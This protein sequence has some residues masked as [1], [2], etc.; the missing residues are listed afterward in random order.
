MSS[1]SSLCT[2]H[3]ALPGAAGW[4]PLAEAARRAARNVGHLRRL[5]VEK[6][7]GEGKAREVSGGGKRKRYEVREDADPAFARVKFPEQMGTDLRHVTESK[8]KEAID[9][10][11]ILDKWERA[12]AG[13]FEL[14]LSEQQITAQ[15]LV[16]LQA[17]GIEVSRATLYNWYKAWRRGGLAGLVDGRGGAVE[18]KTGEVFAKDDQ[19]FREVQ[20][21]Y[22]LPRRLKLSTCCEVARL[23]AEQSGWKTISDERCRQLLKVMPL[24]VVL[25][26]RMG[27]DKDVAY[28]NECEPYIERTYRTMASNEL[29]CGDHHQFDVICNHEGTLLRPW[30]TAWQ[31]MRSRKIVGWKI[32]AHDPNSD[33]ILWTFRRACLDFG[34]CEGVYIDNGKDYDCYSLNGR[35]KADRWRKRVIQVPLNPDRA[36]VFPSLSVEVTHC[37]KYHGQ[38]KPIERF[39]GTVEGDTPVWDTYC[40]RSTSHK[41]EDLQLN[42]ERG[43]APKLC[44]FADWFSAWLEGYHASGSKA[45]DL[46]GKSPEQVYRENLGVIRTTTAAELD[47]HC[48]ARHRGTGEGVKVGQNGV[49]YQ[50]MRFGQYEPSLIALIGKHVELRIDDADLSSVQVWSLDGKIICVAPGNRRVP[51]N[52][53]A[54]ELREAINEKRQAKKAVKQYYEKRPRLSEDLPDLIIRARAKRV[55]TVTSEPLPPPTLQPIRSVISDQM[56]AIRRAIESQPNRLRATGTED[57]S[58]PMSSFAFPDHGQDAHATEDAPS[59]RE[60]MARQS[61][62]VED[63]L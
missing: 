62:R 7:L 61:Q 34:V 18:N 27:G 6:W 52:A 4:L 57:A 35:T 16:T 59:F 21:L 22:L 9:C 15:F 47:A 19:F 26:H 63:E 48:L 23:K 25:L 20:R 5:C 28:T 3:S 40:G 17:R 42:L 58:A 10:K 38:S 60:L 29:W 14:G 33:T 13:R 44:D 31:D 11:A 39:F 41:P 51:A 30:L 24:G 2:L 32:F 55:A 12:K 36:G 1:N 43:K 53:T 50:G 54:Q 46:D 49:M 45:I 8:R 56:P 37:W